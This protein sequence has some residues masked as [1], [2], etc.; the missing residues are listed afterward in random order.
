M[1]LPVLRIANRNITRVPAAETVWLR[2]ISLVK[3]IPGSAGAGTAA[4]PV[5]SRGSPAGEVPATV[6]VFSTAPPS[7]SAWVA[8]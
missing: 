3:V 2:M 1:T 6:A 5:A 7:M 4:E 8:A